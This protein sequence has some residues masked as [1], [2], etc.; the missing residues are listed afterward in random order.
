[1]V[2]GAGHVRGFR[3]RLEAA[4]V[5]AKLVSESWCKVVEGSGQRH[6][7]TSA[8]SRLVEEGFV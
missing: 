7:I 6:E 2:P 3:Y 4:G 8:G 1:V 5:E